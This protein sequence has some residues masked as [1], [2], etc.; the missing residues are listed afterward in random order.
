MD[1]CIF[2]KV[3]NGSFL[4]NLLD[5]VATPSNTEYKKLTVPVANVQS[6]R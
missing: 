2:S 3:K 6:F 1:K 4:S 5:W